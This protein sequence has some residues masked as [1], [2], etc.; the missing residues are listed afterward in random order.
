MELAKTPAWQNYAKN[1]DAAWSA[2]EKNQLSKVT[3]WAT[4]QIPNQHNADSTVFYMFS[5]PDFI[6][7]NALFPK[8]STLVMCG[9]EPVGPTPDVSTLTPAALEKSLQ[10]IRNSL[11]SVMSFSFFITKEMKGDF[12]GHAINGS[13]PIL[14]IFLARSGKTITE[15]Q[16]LNLDAEG[17]LSE[18]PDGPTTAKSQSPGVRIRFLSE[19]GNQPQTLYFFSTDISNGGLA[20]SG[21]LKFCSTLAPGNS[22]VKSA[23]YT[24]HESHFSKIREFLLENSSALVQDDSG[25]PYAFFNEADWNVTLHGRY[26]G[27]IA[28]FKNHHQ[29]KLAELYRSTNPSPLDFGIGYRHR[30]GE[31]TLMVATRKVPLEFSPGQATTRNP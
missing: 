13:L 24:M 19:G 11:D 31:S 17:R 29:P 5:G 30:A 1:F 21:F 28:I 10:S 22:F 15:I 4:A 12:Q 2:L 23:S 6:Y 25:I 20:Q 9:M 27:P 14:S 7:A 16:H 26:L 18:L 8:A 3:Q